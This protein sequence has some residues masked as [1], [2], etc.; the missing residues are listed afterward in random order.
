MKSTTLAEVCTDVSYGYTAS[1]ENNAHGIKFLRI[2][3]IQGGVVNW[4]SVP[5]CQISESDTEKYQL[6]DGDI[7]IA[8][9]GNST[10]ENFIFHGDYQAVYASYLIRFRPNKNLVDPDF[11]WF[12]MRAKSWWDFV[13]SVKTGSAQAGANAQVLGKYP[14]ILPELSTQREIARRL[15]TIYHKIELNTQ[16]NTTLES[17]AKA[18]FKEWFIDFGP[19]KAK[20]EGKKPFG[21]DE[22]TAALFPDGF[23]ESEL[24]MVPRGW[25]VGKLGEEID[26]F[27]G[28]AFKSDKF[29]ESG[30]RLARGDNIKEGEF[31]WG[32]KTRHWSTVTPELERYNLRSGD[33]LIG[34]DGSKVGKN[35]ARVRSFDLPCLL[36]QRVACLRKS[37][38][39]G[40]SYLDILIGS[41]AFKNYIERVKTGTTI[42]H[43]SGKQ[44]KDFHIII[45]QNKQEIFE[46]FEK[47]VEPLAE[48]VT[49][50]LAE[51]RTLEST[52]NLILSKLISGE[53]QLSEVASE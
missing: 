46:L 29:S 34:M 26:F 33:I 17:I 1:A 50:N 38:S 27:T 30:V 19:V 44:I 24:G 7:V 42:P 36:V 45:P 25:R 21:M 37:K 47:T 51:N 4:N 28:F 48:M 39:I 10:G 6:H 3:D 32:D 9:T 2:T 35:W 53:V 20:A 23:E 15:K 13:S 16:I 22:E 31:Q 12:A 14:I 41:I 18:I 49:N 11:I 5:S 43:I 8:R 52:R 40:E